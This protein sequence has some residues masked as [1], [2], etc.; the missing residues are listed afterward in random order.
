MIRLIHTADIHL[1]ACFANANMP[2]NFGNRRRQSLRDV[3]SGILERARASAA[4]AV[5]IAGDLFEHDRVT[6]HSAGV[7]AERNGS[8]EVR[9]RVACVVVANSLAKRSKN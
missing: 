2:P 4:D 7:A 1:D 5:L 9:R 3:F 8:A 6:R